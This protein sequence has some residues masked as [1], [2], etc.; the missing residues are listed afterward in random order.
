VTDIVNSLYATKT[1][2]AFL[3]E[4]HAHKV[5]SQRT[6]GF[7]GLN[8]ERDSYHA[9]GDRRTG[10]AREA[11][12]AGWIEPG[13]AVDGQPERRWWQL[14][15]KGREVLGIKTSTEEKSNG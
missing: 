10:K 1:R 14:T 9:N 7:R 4:V 15:D 12:R 11:E 3:A 13:G 5:Y 2:L 6:A 8:I